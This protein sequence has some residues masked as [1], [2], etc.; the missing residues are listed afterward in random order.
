MTKL[1]VGFRGGNLAPQQGFGPSEIN[2]HMQKIK[3][4][5]IMMKLIENL[6]SGSVVYNTGG[7]RKGIESFF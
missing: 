5:L 1:C 6:F 7:N 3:P 4:D 2:Q